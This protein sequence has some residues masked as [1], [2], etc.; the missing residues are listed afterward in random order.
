M[1]LRAP[2]EIRSPTTA[3]RALVL[4][5]VCITFRLT[6][7]PSPPLKRLGMAPH[8]LQV[9]ASPTSM[10]VQLELECPLAAS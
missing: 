9:A 10:R 5:S 8:R 1:S 3:Y 6:H 2:P 7:N 4:G